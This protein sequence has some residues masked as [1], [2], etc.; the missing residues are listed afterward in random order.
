M[1]RLL[2][3]ERANHGTSRVIGELAALIL[4]EPDRVLGLPFEREVDL[5]GGLLFF[6]MRRQA[7]VQR[8]LAAARQPLVLCGSGAFWSGAGPALRRYVDQTGI[9]AITTSA[10]RGLLTDDHPLSLDGLFHGALAL[11]MADCVLVVGTRFDGNLLLGG[12]PLFPPEQQLV[13]VDRD[14]AAAA[15]GRRPDHFVEGDAGISLDHALRTIRISFR[16]GAPEPG[17][18]S[19]SG[20]AEAEAPPAGRDGTGA[21][22]TEP[23]TG[24]HGQRP[25]SRA[26]RSPRRAGDRQRRQRVSRLPS[27]RERLGARAG[28]HC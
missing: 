1:S 15:S 14:P 24:D 3:V 22:G 27:S 11:P 5:H 25:P 13:L 20:A 9:P 17:R 23:T 16:T 6:G 21:E 12:E 10:A 2:Q 4:R 8:L 28:R 7:E 18:D 26:S 19:G